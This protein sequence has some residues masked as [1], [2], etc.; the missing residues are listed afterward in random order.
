MHNK[1][2]KNSL[3]KICY[4]TANTVS[5]ISCYQKEGEINHLTSPDEVMSSDSVSLSA[6]VC[7]QLKVCHTLH[8]YTPGRSLHSH[9]CPT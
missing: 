4:Q 8:E 1:I 2:K 7:I 6:L 9:L 5:Q 3:G